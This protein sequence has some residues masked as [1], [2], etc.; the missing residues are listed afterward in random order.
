[1]LSDLFHAIVLRVQMG[2]HILLIIGCFFLAAGIFTGRIGHYVKGFALIV[3]G[4]Y[5]AGLANIIR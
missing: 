2:G 3:V 5:I 1:M 4:G